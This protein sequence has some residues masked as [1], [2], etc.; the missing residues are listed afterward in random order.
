MKYDNKMNPIKT[1]KE[2]M[3]VD[4]LDAYIAKI[5]K[6]IQETNEYLAGFKQDNLEDVPKEDKYIALII[7]LICWLGAGTLFITHYFSWCTVYN[8]IKL[9]HRRKNETSRN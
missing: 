3:S 7:I 1:K 6:R 2:P 4:E 9:N 5:D 8:V